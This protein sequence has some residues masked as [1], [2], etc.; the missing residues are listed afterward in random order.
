M[1]PHIV[2]KVSLKWPNNTSAKLYFVLAT[3][4][5]QHKDIFKIFL[6][7]NI[8][9]INILRHFVFCVISYQVRMSTGSFFW[10]FWNYEK[11]SVAL[12]GWLAPLSGLAPCSP[13]VCHPLPMLIGIDQAT[14]DLRQF[15]SSQFF[16]GRN[17][18]CNRRH[19]LIALKLD[20]TL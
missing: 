3:L 20:P 19:R 6:L 16:G 13:T 14:P 1:K 15:A 7:F 4:G 10:I 18:W 8:F 17:V 11:I 5:R 9:K 2:H 12:S